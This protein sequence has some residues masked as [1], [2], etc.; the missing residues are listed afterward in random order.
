VCGVRAEHTD[1]MVECFTGIRTEEI[2]KEIEKRDL[3][4]PE[5]VIIHVGTNELR[6]R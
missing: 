3:G 5:T 2:H 1:M 6:T 4:S